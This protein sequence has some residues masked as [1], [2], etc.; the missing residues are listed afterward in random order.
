M[1]IVMQQRHTQGFHS[2]AENSRLPGFGAAA[3]SACRRHASVQRET[4]E[5]DGFMGMITICMPFSQTQ[6]SKEN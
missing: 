5:S 3:F 1:V 2:P 4:V 6:S